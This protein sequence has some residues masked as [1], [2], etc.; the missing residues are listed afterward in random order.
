VRFY[1]EAFGFRKSEPVPDVVVLRVGEF[2]MR[3]LEKPAGSSP[4]IQ[5]Q[6]QRHYERHWT[7]VHVDIHVGNL[8]EVLASAL[9]AG[10]KQEQLFE[11]P[12]HGSAAF[13][14]DPFGHGVTSSTDK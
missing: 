3:L 1:S 6:Q 14:S 13:C 10:A 2:E 11:N 8:K 12:E 7:L 4:S 9:M 5:S